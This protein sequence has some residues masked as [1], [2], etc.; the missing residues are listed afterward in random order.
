MQ[1]HFNE[2]PSPN[3]NQNF[4]QGISHNNYGGNYD[5]FQEN[6]DDD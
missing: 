4:N 6:G 2:G 3:T 5:N 1:M